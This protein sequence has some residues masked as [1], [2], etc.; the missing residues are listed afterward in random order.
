MGYL[1]LPV[2]LP[3]FVNILNARR[4]PSMYTKYFILNNSSQSQK[5]KY[6][7][8]ILPDI[9]TAILLETLFIEPVGLGDL[10]A[11]MVASD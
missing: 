11:F 4:Q 10:P 7:G 2:N 6:F 9:K 8:A 3:D 5:I 1:L